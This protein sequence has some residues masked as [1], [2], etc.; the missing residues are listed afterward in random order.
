M[1]KLSLQEI[2]SSF[3]NISF[4]KKRCIQILKIF[5]FKIVDYNG[6]NDI[7]YFNIINE[8]SNVK[9]DL[10]KFTAHSLRKRK[11][12]LFFDKDGYIEVEFHE[13]YGDFTMI[14][15]PLRFI[16]ETD[17]NIRKEIESFNKK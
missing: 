1:N 12:Y 14:C 9:I 2:K 13:G 3:E 15:I 11:V 16:Y 8:A 10:D 17:E 6:D 5:N 4:L 7:K